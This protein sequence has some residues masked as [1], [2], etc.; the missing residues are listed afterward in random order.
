MP[1]AFTEFYWRRSLLPIACVRLSLSLSL[2]LFVI[3]T[4][5]DLLAGH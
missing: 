2:S 1:A 4:E 3:G 5:A